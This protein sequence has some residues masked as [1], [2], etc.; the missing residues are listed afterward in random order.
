M[1]ATAAEA[2]AAEATAAATWVAATQAFLPTSEELRAPAEK[3][4]SREISGWGN[5]L[6]RSQMRPIMHV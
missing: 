6:I 4:R 2:T 1:E 5:G 3:Q